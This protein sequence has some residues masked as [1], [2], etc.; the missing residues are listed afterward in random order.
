MAQARIA[1]T[2]NELLGL[3]EEFNF[4]DSTTPEF[5]IV[6]FN[7]NFAVPAIGV[8][9]SLHRVDVRDRRKVEIFAPH[10]WRKLR[11]DCLASRNITSA[12]AR[13]DHGGA[14]PILTCAFVVGRRGRRRYC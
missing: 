12:G 4:T 11:E 3:R 1:P 2:R 9:L 8:N 7:G 10:E 13:L 5:D 6:A 14:L